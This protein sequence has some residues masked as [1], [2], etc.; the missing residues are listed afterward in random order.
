MAAAKLINLLALV[1]VALAALSFSVTPVNALS[2]RSQHLNRHISHD[3]MAKRKRDAPKR[4]KTRP[5]SSAVPAALAQA[6]SHSTSHST[7]HT[8]SHTSST[9]KAAATPAGGNGAAGGGSSGFS[10]THNGP[11]K[12]GLA[13]PNGV[14]NLNNFLTENVKMYVLNIV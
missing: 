7:T 12:V 9:A 1:A 6:T 13:W 8:T 2:G 10:T 5:S 3:A 4:C 11:G 14:T